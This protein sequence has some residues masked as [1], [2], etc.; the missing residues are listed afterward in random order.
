[1]RDDNPYETPK[2]PISG[3][4]PDTKRFLWC[5]LAVFGC[6]ALGALLGLII[7]GLLG[8][9]APGYY[10][11]VFAAGNDPDFNPVALG[12]GLGLTQG[13]VFGAIIGI[14]LVAITSWHQ[15]RMAKREDEA[16]AG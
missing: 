4:R 12:I 5:V 15:S 7:G 3:D 10:R 11:A 2:E 14:A 1:M 8:A 13:V 6:S 9:A 16:N